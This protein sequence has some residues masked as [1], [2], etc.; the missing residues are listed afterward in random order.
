MRE[1]SESCWGRETGIGNGPQGS[2]GV[3]YWDELEDFFVWPECQVGAPGRGLLKNEV[4][5]WAGPRSCRA[6][7][8]VK[9][10]SE[11]KSRLLQ[12]FM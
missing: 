11:A 12:R 6:W 4:E 9:L 1:D 7:N 2:E 3:A 10:H 8:R 5:R